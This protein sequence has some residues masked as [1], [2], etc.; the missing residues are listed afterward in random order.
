MA[1]ITKGSLG[2]MCNFH[3]DK[4]EEI[5][6]NTLN[7]IFKKESLFVEVKYRIACIVIIH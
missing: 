2:Y 1:L 5:I 7:S 6:K 3:V 4:Y